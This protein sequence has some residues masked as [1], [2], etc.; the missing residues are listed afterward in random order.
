MMRLLV[1]VTCPVR[2]RLQDKFWSASFVQLITVNLPINQCAAEQKAR[3]RTTSTATS[4]AGRHGFR[5]VRVLLL[6]FLV[7]IL[8]YSKI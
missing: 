5:F 1:P 2:R 7:G 4:R 8:R 3:G 6:L